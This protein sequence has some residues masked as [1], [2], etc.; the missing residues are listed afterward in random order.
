MALHKYMLE[1]E[2]IEVSAESSIR[3]SKTA[4][5]ILINLNVT[6]N[7]R[8]FFHKQWTAGEPRRLL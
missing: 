2:D 3:A 8:L 7:A 4:F 6:R 1:R 5:H